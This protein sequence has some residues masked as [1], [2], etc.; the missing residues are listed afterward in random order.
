MIT[1]RSSLCLLHCHKRNIKLFCFFNN[2]FWIFF[3]NYDLHFLI[4]CQQ[5]IHIWE[6]SRKHL[7]CFFL[8]PHTQ[9]NIR[10][11]G[12]FRSEE[13]TSELQSRGHLVCR[14]LLEKK[15][16]DGTSSHL[17]LKTITD[18]NWRWEAE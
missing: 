6:K 2:S 13:H 17:H 16:L 11:E 9:A 14:L 1:D 4:P 3:A 8:T 10:I 15:T 5:D 12:Y 18:V 7:S